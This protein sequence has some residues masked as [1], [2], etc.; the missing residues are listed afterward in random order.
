MSDEKKSVIRFE[1]ERSEKAKWV[2]KANELK[3]KL[4]EYIRAR[5]NGDIK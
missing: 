1:V 5:V 3:L 2:R 4:S